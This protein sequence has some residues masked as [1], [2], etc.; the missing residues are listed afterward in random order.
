MQTDGCFLLDV[1][2]YLEKVPENPKKGMGYLLVRK[3]TKFIQ[4]QTKFLIKHEEGC[5]SFCQGLFVQRHNK[6]KKSCQDPELSYN[7]VK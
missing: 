5:G 6:Y 7:L 1:F 2:Q 3:H 4:S